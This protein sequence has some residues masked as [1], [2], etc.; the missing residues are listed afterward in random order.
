MM[1]TKPML[2]QLSVPVMIWIDGLKNEFNEE[3]KLIG[4]GRIT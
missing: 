2:R 4:R 1:A 3:V